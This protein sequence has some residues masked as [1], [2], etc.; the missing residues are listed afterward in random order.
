VRRSH[1]GVRSE[2]GLRAHLQ[3]KPLLLLLAFASGASAHDHA[4]PAPFSPQR[5]RLEQSASEPVPL[6]INSREAGRFF[7]TTSERFYLFG[8]PIVETKVRERWQGQ[9]DGPGP[10]YRALK[11]AFEVRRTMPGWEL[12]VAPKPFSN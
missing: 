3:M 11:E 6:L 12:R 1:D 2:A 5:F 7:N 8:K 9:F 4:A 10:G